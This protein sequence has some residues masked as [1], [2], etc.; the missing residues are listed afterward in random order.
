M[1]EEILIAFDAML[2]VKGKY[3]KS[4]SNTALVVFDYNS[5]KEFGEDYQEVKARLKQSILE[6]ASK[7]LEVEESDIYISFNTYEI[8]G[9]MQC[10]R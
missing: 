3:S 4:V 9:R 8:I 10:K 6:K 1:K 5:L 7:E 2:L